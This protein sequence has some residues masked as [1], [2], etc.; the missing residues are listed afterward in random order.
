VESVLRV[1]EIKILSQDIQDK[2]VSGPGGISVSLKQ[3]STGPP[4][5]GRE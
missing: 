1:T 4:E 3:L 2:G 5:H